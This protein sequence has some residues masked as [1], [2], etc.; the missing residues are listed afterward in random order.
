MAVFLL[1]YHDVSGVY[2]VLFP[3]V[4]MVHVVF[5]EKLKMYYKYFAD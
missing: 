4:I 1:F 5:S 2:F 3:W